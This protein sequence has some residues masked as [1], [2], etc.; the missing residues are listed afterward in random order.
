[1][2]IATLTSLLTGSWLNAA[3]AMG[4]LALAAFV[5]DRLC[6]TAGR[7]SCVW[8]ALGIQEL[9]WRVLSHWFAW[10]SI[11]LRH[12]ASVSSELVVELAAVAGTV[13]CFL[14]LQR[15]SNPAPSLAGWA[16]FLLI[17]AGG[18]EP[19][20]RTDLAIVRRDWG[21]GGSLGCMVPDSQTLKHLEHVAAMH[22]G[23]APVVVVASALIV[24]CW[25]QTTPHLIVSERCP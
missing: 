10:G 19:A 12:G 8:A 5:V 7:R 3:I 11:T 2:I 24:F 18:W 1:M 6:R 25:L 4:A 21:Y 20:W 16:V 9:V 13:W 17:V 23:L 22:L 15:R 14:A